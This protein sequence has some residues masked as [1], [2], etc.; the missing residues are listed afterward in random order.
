MNKY[1]LNIFA[2][3]WSKLVNNIELLF[4][5]LSIDVIFL[6]IALLIYY[7]YTICN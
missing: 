4:I 2:K 1:L 6:F 5:M 3:I 7:L